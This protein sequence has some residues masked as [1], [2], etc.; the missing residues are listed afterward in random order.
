MKIPSLKKRLRNFQLPDDKYCLM[1]NDKNKVQ[2]KWPYSYWPNKLDAEHMLVYTKTI[3]T[4]HPLPTLTAGLPLLIHGPSPHITTRAKVADNKGFKQLSH[5][6]VGLPTPYLVGGS[7]CCLGEVTSSM[8]HP[9]NEKYRSQ[10][11][12]WKIFLHKWLD[13]F[14]VESWEVNLIIPIINSITS[15]LINLQTEFI[16]TICPS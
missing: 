13:I 7:P 14:F 16:A 6:I 3:I 9:N 10:S 12:Y 5:L 15:S 11:Y 2:R 1:K 4:D 8:L